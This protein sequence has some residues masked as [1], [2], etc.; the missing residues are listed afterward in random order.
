MRTSE[1][2]DDELV[3]GVSGNEALVIRDFAAIPTS[4]SQ[5]LLTTREK[6]M[7]DPTDATVLAPAAWTLGQAFSVQVIAVPAAFSELQ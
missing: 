5:I 3:L 1:G 2:Q 4:Q 6:E 7:T